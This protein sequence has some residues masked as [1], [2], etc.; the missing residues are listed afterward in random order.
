[1][2]LLGNSK[3][4]PFPTYSA[5]GSHTITVSRK[6]ATA[7]NFVQ[8]HAQSQVLNG[9]SC[10]VSEIQKTGH[11]QRIRAWEVIRPQFCEKM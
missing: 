3:Y 9:F 10:T 8:C 7:I 4:W 2:H 5:M 11:S 1:M 6:Y